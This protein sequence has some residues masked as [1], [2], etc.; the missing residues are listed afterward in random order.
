KLYALLRGAVDEDYR[1]GDD[2]KAAELILNILDWTD[3][4]DDRSDID[5][6]GNLVQAGGAG[7]NI[8]YAKHGYRARNAKMD[9]VE[10]VR[11]VEG[12][13]DDLFC[14]FGKDFT[15]YN[16]TKV[17]VNEADLQLLKAILCD[18]LVEQDPFPVCWA[19]SP[20]QPPPMDMALGMMQACRRIKQALFTPAFSSENDF[21]A[22]FQRLP[23]PLN[24]LIRLNTATLR[25]MIGTRTKILRINARGWVGESGH[26]ITAVVDTSSMNY[27]YWKETG[28]DSTDKMKGPKKDR[29]ADGT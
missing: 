6:N 16:T 18:N 4:D 28:F 27:L 1:G 19:A 23:E 7:E 12:M 20:G 29:W 22:F 14:R 8:D 9:S 26:E 3:P 5:S 15:V 11:L 17:N 25:P 2:R 13:T 24:Q 21:L 10:E